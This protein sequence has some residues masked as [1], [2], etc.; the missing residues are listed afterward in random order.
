MTFAE[1]ITSLYADVTNKNTRTLTVLREVTVR[2]LKELS[3]IRT[4]MMESTDTFPTVAAQEGYT[5]GS[6]GMAA[7]V[8]AIDQLYWTSGNTRVEI[9]GPISVADLRFK[10]GNSG[11]AAHPS[12]WSWNANQLLLGPKPLGVITLSMDYTR[13]ATLDTLTGAAITTASTIQTNPWFDRG[14]AALR[15]AVL[16]EYFAMP[17]WRDQ[18]AAALATVGKNAAIR[19]MKNEWAARKFRGGQ[20]PE[21][22][23][24][25]DLERSDPW[26]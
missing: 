21:C 4:L 2:Q 24:D 17:A 19:S 1:F 18:E 7:D 8:L 22:W 10:Y 16:A 23:G 25:D 14:Q 13:D 20:A 15:N 3:A 5:P 12:C 11:G 6:G 26:P 9:P